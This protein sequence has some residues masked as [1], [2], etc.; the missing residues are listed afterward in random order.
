MSLII[1]ILILFL[2]RYHRRA[3][4]RAS[5]QPVLQDEFAVRPRAFACR[6]GG[7]EVDGAT[8]VVAM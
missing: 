3:M 8:T 1:V 5:T 2:L 7:A 6:R 4:D